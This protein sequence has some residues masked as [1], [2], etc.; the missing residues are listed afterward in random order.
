[1]E[2]LSISESSFY[3]FESL[4]NSGN[5]GFLKFQLVYFLGGGIAA[6]SKQVH[7]TIRTDDEINY[8]ADVFYCACKIS[9]ARR[10]SLRSG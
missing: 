7:L 2:K 8:L 9:N 6:S 10:N 3:F 1:M 5:R 4:F